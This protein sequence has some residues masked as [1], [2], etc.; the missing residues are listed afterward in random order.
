MVA[1]S[2]EKIENVLECFLADASNAK[3][4]GKKDLEKYYLEQYMRFWNLMQLFSKKSSE[5]RLNIIR[6]VFKDNP[7][8]LDQY[9]G[10]GIIYYIVKPTS[11][12]IS[13]EVTQKEIVPSSSIKSDKS[14]AEVVINQIESVYVIP[15]IPRIRMA[16]SILL[17]DPRV[18]DQT[19][20]V[21]KTLQKQELSKEKKEVLEEISLLDSRKRDL[22]KEQQLY[23]ENYSSYQSFFGS[24]ELERRKNLLLQKT[25]KVDQILEQLERRVSEISQQIK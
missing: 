25:D 12:Q 11:V 3:R 10:A 16:F 17:N 9:Q 4:D 18:K 14:P 20:Q 8:E 23:V 21:V 5:S 2:M 15:S 6:S 24:V 13:D 7:L 1:D 22:I 19:T